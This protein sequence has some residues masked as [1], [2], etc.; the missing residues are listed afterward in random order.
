M[1]LPPYRPGFGTKPNL[2]LAQAA[3]T[4]WKWREHPDFMR[5]LELYRTAY[6]WEA[7]EVWESLWQL[8][9]EPYKNLI[10]A[11]IKLTA[12]RLKLV[13]GDHDAAET[14]HTG[15]RRLFQ[16]ALENSQE[17]AEVTALIQ[18]MDSSLGAPPKH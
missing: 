8:T 6:F 14:L 3:M 17:P 5:G 10:Q 4:N 16:K 15:A 1:K 11:A 12:S 18:T 9:N 13:M 2:D 7:H